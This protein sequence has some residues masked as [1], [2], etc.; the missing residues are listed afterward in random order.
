MSPAGY[1]LPVRANKPAA[2]HAPAVSQ[3]LQPGI[4]FTPAN[5]QSPGWLYTVLMFVCFTVISAFSALFIIEAMQAIPGN[6]HFQACRGPPAARPGSVEYG[7]L[8]NFYFG[9]WAHIIGQMFLFGALQSNAVQNIILAAQASDTLLI[10][11][12]GKTCGLAIS[13]DTKGWIVLVLVIPLGLVNLDDNIGVQIGAFAISLLILLQWCTSAIANGLQSSRM[14]LLRPLGWSYGQVV[15][16]VML[17]LAITTIVPSWINMK[18]KDVNAQHVVWSSLSFTTIVLVAVGIFPALGFDIGASNN[19]L[20]VISSNGMPLIL[21]EI[22][23]YMFA[24]VM[25]I[26]SI[27]VN[28]LISKSNLFQNKV[29]PENVASALSFVVPWIVSIPLQTGN[30]MQPFQSWTSI[31][32]VSTSNFIIPIIIF[33]R[34]HEFRR[35]YNRDRILTD[36]QR[37]LLKSIHKES[38][39]IQDYIDAPRRPKKSRRK[40]TLSKKPTTLNKDD[41]PD[42]AA[43]Q[44]PSEQTIAEVPAEAAAAATPQTS[45]ATP[46]ATLSVPRPASGSASPVS[47]RASALRID[48]SRNASRNSTVRFDVAAPPRASTTS[49]VLAQEI[50]FGESATE[51]GAEDEESEEIEAADDEECA[52]GEEGE[53]GD[54]DDVEGDESGLPSYMLLDVPDPDQEYMEEVRRRQTANVARRTTT[55]SYLF[56]TLSRQSNTMSRIPDQDT[57]IDLVP[58]Q[59]TPSRKQRFGDDA[60]LP[61]APPVLSVTPPMSPAARTSSMPGYTPSPLGTSSPAAATDPSASL[62]PPGADQLGLRRH[63][64]DHS[65][66]ASDLSGS[67]GSED[68][69]HEGAIGRSHSRGTRF[70]RRMT[71]PTN[72]QFKSPA[73]RSVP[74]WIPLRPIYVAWFVLAVTSL[75]TLANGIFNF[76][77]PSSS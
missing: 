5:F 48:D 1:T 30:W 56:G 11:I 38:S 55:V 17:N 39:T 63:S 70:N 62:A 35:N 68:E 32:F 4:P 16:T 7:T 34:C 33:L 36:K 65:S 66:A 54:D 24:Y 43:T 31:I 12:F 76:I 18:R 29:V 20:P 2:I 9:P 46:S 41:K 3:P 42:V 10:S 27:P 26:P 58:V 14:P 15:G 22:T 52:E 53:E 8:I 6:R 40:R 13:G 72:P 61:P 59:S 23:V 25:L 73:F 51:H 77:A 45:S 67:Q 19:I 60:P 57:S 69:D 44:Q 47:P 49:H 74:K 75:V 71:L 37:E 21:S 50:R 64:T 28:L